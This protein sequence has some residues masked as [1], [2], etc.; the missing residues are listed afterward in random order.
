MPV[1]M[2]LKDPVGDAWLIFSQTSD[3]ITKCEEDSF[4]E[5]GIPLQQFFVL[6]VIKSIPD[7][8][9]PSIVANWV[10]RN[11]NSITLIIDRME[12]EGLVKRVRD[13]KDRRALRLIITAKGEEK[14]KLGRKPARELQEKIL[15]VLTPEEL[16]TFAVLLRR[17]REAT[18]EYRNIKDKVRDVS[19]PQAVG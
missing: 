5:V 3:S 14:I 1:R 2:T 15:S 16:T 8:V 13:L 6:S 12:K 19:P 17:V 4:A 11:Q 9:T 7:P 18:F 10:D